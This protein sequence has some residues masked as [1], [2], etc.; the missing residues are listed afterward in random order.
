MPHYILEYD[1]DFDYCYSIGV[2]PDNV[3]DFIHRRLNNWGWHW[4]QYSVWIL[5]FTTA[6]LAHTDADTLADQVDI[7]YNGGAPGVFGKL[8]LQRYIRNYRIR[9]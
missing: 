3:Y 4:L 5:R 9:G 6:A 8:Y 2:D 7:H 1:L